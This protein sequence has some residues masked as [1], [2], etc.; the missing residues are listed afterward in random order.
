[1][2]LD[3]NTTPSLSYA[4]IPKEKWQSF[5]D[6]FTKTLEG[7]HVEIEVVGLAFGDQI[8]AEWL[9]LNGLTYDPKADTFYI[10]AEGLEHDIDHAVPHP[11]EI[12]VR[13]GPDGIEDVVAIDPEQNQHIVHLRQPL[14]LP[15]PAS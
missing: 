1:M 6:A 12:L 15:Q 11:R 8:E 10:Y 3:T 7:R 2:S 14:L 9:P 13:T 5:F 4:P